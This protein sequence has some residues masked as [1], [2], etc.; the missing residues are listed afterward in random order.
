MGE[1]LKTF[2]FDEPYGHPRPCQVDSCRTLVLSP[3]LF[4][5]PHWDLVSENSQLAIAAALLNRAHE[6]LRDLLDE[7][8][9]RIEAAETRRN[10][11][12]SA[13]DGRQ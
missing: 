5:T 12:K 8:V 9:G 11:R 1:R 3:C 7:V 13:R 10:A 2:D 6:K 4:C